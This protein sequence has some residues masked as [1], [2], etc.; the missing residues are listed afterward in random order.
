MEAFPQWKDKVNE[1]I[2]KWYHLIHNNL[3]ESPSKRKIFLKM[4]P[5]SLLRTAR[6]TSSDRISFN[7]QSIH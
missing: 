5:P 4:V 1:D 2:G 6:S 7:I 3:A